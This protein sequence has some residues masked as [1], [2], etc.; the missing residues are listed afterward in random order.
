M[1]CICPAAPAWAGGYSEYFSLAWRLVECARQ[2]IAW[3]LSVAALAATVA[4]LSCMTV[5][6]IV[7]SQV[8]TKIK[9][10]NCALDVCALYLFGLLAR[11]IRGAASLKTGKRPGGREGGMKEALSGLGQPAGLQQLSVLWG[12]SLPAAVRQVS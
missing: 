11:C 1:G 2:R 4:P 7:L 6:K 3:L 5:D 10:V 9:C 8:I 12:C